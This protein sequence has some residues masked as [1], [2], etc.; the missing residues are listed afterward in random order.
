[1]PTNPSKDERAFTFFTQA[2]KTQQSFTLIELQQTSGYIAGT[3]ENYI[4]KKWK[5]FLTPFPNGTYQV[6]PSFAYY[7]LEQFLKDL[8]QAIPDP[9]APV[10]L[11]I[12]NDDQLLLFFS[13]VLIFLWWQVNRRYNLILSW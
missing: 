12:W 9:L 10:R 2:M 5:R 1:M 11:T 6:L 3:I 4:K 13:L 7:L 8:R